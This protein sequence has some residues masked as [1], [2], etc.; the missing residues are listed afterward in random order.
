MA[1]GT[2]VCHAT[3]T[4]HGH[5]GDVSYLQSESVFESPQKLNGDDLCERPENESDSFGFRGGHNVFSSS[6]TTLS[7]LCS[8]NRVFSDVYHYWH[9]CSYCSQISFFISS[10]LS[11]FCLSFLSS[12]SYPSSI[13][14]PSSYPL[15]FVLLARPLF[16]QSIHLLQT[17]WLSDRASSFFCVPSLPCFLVRVADRH[18]HYLPNGKGLNCLLQV[19]PWSLPLIC[20]SPIP[21]S[22]QDFLLLLSTWSCV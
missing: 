5:D 11:P 18:R 15:T 19:V 17:D 6:T 2:Y 14:S 9:F 7:H 16:S 21:L 12:P 10:A 3:L 13:S 20:R 4:G 1:S 8:S 22:R